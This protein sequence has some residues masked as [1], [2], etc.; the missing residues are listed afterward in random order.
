MGTWLWGDLPLPGLSS[1]LMR[2]HFGEAFQSLQ[3]HSPN[4][5][6][7][8]ESPEIHGTDT[9]VKQDKARRPATAVP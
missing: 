6:S 5:S 3:I 4:P 1:S 2:R 8:P 7:R 9:K